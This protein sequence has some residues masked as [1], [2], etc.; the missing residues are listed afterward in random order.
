MR[1]LEPQARAEVIK[2]MMYCFI[3]KG[4]VVFS[5]GS[6]GNYFYIIKEGKVELFIDGLKKKSLHYGESLGELALLH[7]A[8]RSGTIKTAEDTYMWCLERKK[9]KQVIDYINN[10]N[11]E[12]N[13][14]FI[15]SIP[16]LNN[17]DSDT[18]TLL[19]SN[20]IKEIYDSGSYIVKEGESADCIYIIKEGD[21]ICTKKQEVIRTLNKGD[22]F[23]LQAVLSETT[24]SLNVVA[25]SNCIV[26]SLSTNNLISILGPEFRD[27]LYL[28]YIKMCLKKSKFF[29]KINSSLL[30]NIYKIF[31]LK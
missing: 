30:E 19:S 31:R 3:P 4:T 24:R 7:G 5:Q 14:A 13:R 9:F 20:L 1:N 28:S 22:F 26:Y 6:R 10:R 21:V 12:E 2:Q 18:I 27:V 23:G 8:L 29:S 11:F 17:L 15:Q 16:M 25:K